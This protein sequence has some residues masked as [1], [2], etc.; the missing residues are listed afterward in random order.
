[1]ETRSHPILSISI[2]NLGWASV[3]CS[4]D[5]Y[6]IFDVMTPDGLG[7]HL[8]QPALLRYLFQLRGSHMEQTPF[9]NKHYYTEDQQDNE[10]DNEYQSNELEMIINEKLWKGEQIKQKRRA[11]RT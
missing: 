5:Q 11:K 7:I 6:V 9:F 10:D 3:Q 1:M 4:R 8:R 2:F